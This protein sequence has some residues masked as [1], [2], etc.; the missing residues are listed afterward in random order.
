MQISGDSINGYIRA[1]LGFSFRQNPLATSGE[2]FADMFAN[3]A[4]DEFT[5]DEY[6]YARSSWM[7]KHMPAWIAALLGIP[8]PS[9]DSR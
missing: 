8:L 9:D 7:E 1:R 5:S 6:G 3:W 2:D 4:Y